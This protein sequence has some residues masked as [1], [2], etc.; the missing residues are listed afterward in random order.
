MNTKFNDILF[1]LCHPVGQLRE[2]NRQ[3]DLGAI[4]EKLADLS[5]VP[6]EQITGTVALALAHQQRDGADGYDVRID[7]TVRQALCSDLLPHEEE[8]E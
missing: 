5:G 7:G 3:A 4:E 1:C 6:H 2:L 8:E